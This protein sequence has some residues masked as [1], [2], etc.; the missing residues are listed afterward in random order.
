MNSVGF[1]IIGCGNIGP[2]HAM[3][4]RDSEHAHLVG[5]SD[6]NEELAGKL[7]SEHG[8]EA[9]GDYKTMLERDDIQ[10]VSICVP[11]GLRVEI[12]E[13]VA[14]AGK[15]VLSEKPLEVTSAKI[16]RIIAATEK[17]G[18]KLGCIFQSRFSDGALKIR[19][20]VDDG[21]FGKLVLGD[22]YIKWYRSQEYYDSGAWRGTI[23]LDGGGALMNQGIHQIDLLQWFMGPVKEVTAKKAL[24]AHKDIEVED[25]AC[26]LLEFENGAFGV[27]EG[28]TAIWPGHSERVEV[29]GTAGSVVLESG[30]IRSWQFQEELPEDKAIQAALDKDADLGSGAGDP[31]AALKHEGHRRQIEDFALAILENRSPRIQGA[32]GRRAVALIEAIYKSA[33]EGQPVAVS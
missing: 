5:V 21:R 23:K 17:A 4:I 11:S 12:A 18:V 30:E 29:H 33:D 2:V 32:E 9:F 22:A 15:H 8:A 1:G 27:I 6:L 19:K 28:S 16:D 24:V 20:A 25:I 13:T 14:A 26:V 3:A 10:A 31:L 7:A